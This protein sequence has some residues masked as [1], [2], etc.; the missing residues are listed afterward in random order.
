MRTINVLVTGANSQ[1]AKTLKELYFINHCNI[2]FSFKDRKELDISDS[3]KVQNA[4]FKTKYD[5]CINTAAYT[6]V[7]Q[8][9]KTPYKAYRI[10]EL[11]VKNLI[12]GCKINNTILIHIS[13]DYVFDGKAIS[14]YTET[15]SPNPINEYGKSKLY[16]ENAILN[17]LKNYFII[18]T[19]W[20]Y[21]K[22]KNNF[23]KTMIKLGNEK[24]EIN[25]INDQFGC[26]TNAEDLCHFIFYIITHNDIEYGLYHFSNTGS[27]NWFEF[28]REVFELCD[29][30]TKITPISS[31]DYADSVNRPQYSIMS[32][33]KIKQNSGIH[34]LDWKESL[35]KELKKCFK[36]KNNFI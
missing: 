11:G 21:S 2:N 24:D 31:E 17:E 28:A 34:L 33:N 35:K 26:P 15:D 12:E 1:L 14:P 22:F 23:V 4:F 9:E 27:T 10:N 30:K 18:R 36:N 6:N 13:T 8:S 16:G 3:K 29:L 32:K 7:K 19:S 5:Y 25:V 20:L